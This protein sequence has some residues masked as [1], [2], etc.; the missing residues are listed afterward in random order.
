VRRGAV[1]G[2]RVAFAF[3]FAFAFT[4]AF[5]FAGGSAWAEKPTVR[6]GSKAF[7]EGVILGEIA[8]YL[9]ER[10]GATAEHRRELGGTRILWDALVAGE[11]D[12]YVEYTGTIRE[13]IL[14]GTPLPDDD[15]LREA[16]R[17]RGIRMS[18]PLGF[19][20]TYA[21]GMRERRA[22]ELGIRTISDL[23]AHPS[24]RFGVSNEFMDRGDGWPALQRRYALPQTDVRGLDHDLAYRGVASGSIDLTDLYSTDAEIRFYGLRVLVDDLAHF[25]RYD[26][27]LLVRDDLATRAPRA[28]E[29]MLALEGSIDEPSMI[30]M[31]AR[32]KLD[33]VAEQQVAADFVNARFGLGVTAAVDSRAARIGRR[34]V[35]HLVLVA[36]SLALALAIGL[37]LG[38]AA[39]RLPRLGQAIL[40]SA[41]L[42]QT[43]PALALL[44]ALIPSLGIGAPPAIAAL[45]VYSLLPIV[46]NTHAGLTGIAGPIRESAAALG[47]G[48]GAILR[49]VE[50]PL[51]AP[52]ILAG[53]KTAAI[54]NVGTATLGALVGAG[55]YGQPILT[56]I[57]L[58]DTSLL[59]EGALPAAALALLVQ[60]L[61]ELVERAVVPRGLRLRPHTSL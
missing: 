12:A 2:L 6:I 52:T 1:R 55:G 3:A 47:L 56:G 36:L 13:E 9:A 50:L 14:A 33:R 11:I 58:A 59:L 38:V 39:S 44:V 17:A 29:A 25:P 31:N 61:F 37:P 5:A 20:D 49:R 32:A 53:V 15:A 30:A 23:R 16:L 22:D 21:L 24:L 45:F 26:A 54:I 28:L 8:R 35:E 41:G 40:A 4:F 48:K 19:N 10:G 43:I 34:T 42:V 57:R 46:R 7:T 27:V 60:G 51:A 18:R